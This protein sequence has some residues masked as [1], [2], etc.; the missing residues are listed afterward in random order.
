MKLV[1]IKNLSIAVLMVGSGFQISANWQDLLKQ[2]AI[3]SAQG[4]KEAA[5]A[6]A[7]TIAASAQTLAE[8]AARHYQEL[9]KV[10]NE[11]K[12]KAAT[13]ALILAQKLA[14][15]TKKLGN[16]SAAQAIVH[17]LSQAT[18]FAQEHPIACVAAAYSALVA[19][20]AA[21][22]LWQ[23]HKETVKKAKVKKAALALKVAKRAQAIR[24]ELANLPYSNNYRQNYSVSEKSSGNLF[25]LLAIMDH[26][27]SFDDNIS[28]L[29]YSFFNEAE[30][31]LDNYR[32]YGYIG[33]PTFDK[34]DNLVASLIDIVK[35]NDPEN[36][37]FLAWICLG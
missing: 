25:D 18:V 10:L 29:C 20:N 5:Q 28:I 3:L 4:A 17:G 37:E 24:I 19:T 9:A 26:N 11:S 15:T 12:D 2:G 14:D 6:A 8:A 21:Y 35:E 13:Q 36:P 34:L 30:S 27:T 7:N 16:T 23:K 31:G 32:V 22:F 1:S 33:K